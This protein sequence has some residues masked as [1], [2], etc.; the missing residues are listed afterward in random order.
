V[1]DEK[2]IFADFLKSKSLKRTRQRFD[3]LDIFMSAGIHISAYE[4]HL[5]IKKKHP[6]IGFSTI[7]RTLKLLTESGI[8]DEGNFGDG[9]SRYEAAFKRGNHGHLICRECGRTEEFDSEV[10]DKVQ[11]RVVKKYGYEVRGRRFEIYGLCS[12]CVENS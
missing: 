1:H 4:L 2:E 7:Y 5:R 12:K 8:A 3:I 6:E 10:I 11:K 9:Q